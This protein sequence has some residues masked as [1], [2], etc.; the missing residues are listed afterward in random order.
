MENHHF[1]WVNQL[2]QWPFSNSYVKLPEGKDAD[3]PVRSYQRA[4]SHG[5]VHQSFTRLCSGCLG[6]PV[7]VSARYS[8]I[9]QCFRKRTPMNIGI[10]N[11]GKATYCPFILL[12]IADKWWL[13]RP[14]HVN[15]LENIR[16]NRIVD[17]ICYIS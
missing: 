11:C 9:S 10:Y 14:I 15:L 1:S 5:P 4:P 16:V 8:Q 6:G 17:S 7:F 12:L 13:V 2:F 3:F